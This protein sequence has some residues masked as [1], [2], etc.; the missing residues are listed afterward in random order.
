M[1]RWRVDEYG[2]A[3]LTY[4]R[5]RVQVFGPSDERVSYP[6]RRRS[7]S[8]SWA[9]SSKSLAHFWS[10]WDSRS[11][12]GVLDQKSLWYLV[13]N[14]VGSAVLAFEAAVPTAGTRV[15]G[16]LGGQPGRCAQSQQ[17]CADP[18]GQFSAVVI[19]R[20]ARQR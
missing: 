13:L 2:C 11:P 15:G 8:S 7:G 19:A 4:S 10:W 1:L 5:S 16:C 9:S 14:T 17:E 18:T 20:D 6:V 12:G 3:Y